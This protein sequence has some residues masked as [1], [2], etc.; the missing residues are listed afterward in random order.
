MSIKTILSDDDTRDDGRRLRLFCLPYAA[1]S[2]RIFSGW[3]RDLPGFVDVCPLELPGHGRR[4]HE[5]PIGD[6]D[7]LM[8]DLLAKVLPLTDR[9]FAIL[10]YEYGAVLGFEMA[11]RLERHFDVVP[12]HLFVTAMRAPVW[13]RPANPVSELSDE[14]FRELLRDRTGCSS[15]LLQSD[16]VME[17][18]I[19]VLRADF[20][21][22]DNYQ[23]V[24]EMAVTCPITA[25]RGRDDKVVSREAIQAWNVCTKGPFRWQD[26]PG[27]HYF[28]Y[29]ARELFLRGLSAELGVY[30]K[31][32]AS[33]AG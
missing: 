4:N 29:R 31:D 9:P 16:S 23:Y 3:R 5:P 30:A 2:A 1:G 24:P 13:P 26:L 33:V 32:S 20:R 12:R 15:D 19:R 22:A 7:E 10:G 14:N 6:L 17:F 21:I 25:F 27:G 18:A 11:H 8:A 28:M